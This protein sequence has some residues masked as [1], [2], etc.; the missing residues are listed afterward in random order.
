MKVRKRQG[1][2]ATLVV[3]FILVLCVLAAIPALKSVVNA[4]ADAASNI[5]QD[6]VN[7]TK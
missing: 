5:R 2:I 6:I 3:T 4:N 7:V 1:G